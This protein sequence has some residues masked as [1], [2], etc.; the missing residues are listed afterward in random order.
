M[1]EN[2]LTS[3]ASSGT[4]DMS[5]TTSRSLFLAAL[6]SWL[7]EDEMFLGVP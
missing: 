5:P 7:V 3:L 4:P 6:L 2:D 1:A